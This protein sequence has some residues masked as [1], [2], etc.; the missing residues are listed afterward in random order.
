MC[1]PPADPCAGQVV[2]QTFPITAACLSPTSSL[3]CAPATITVACGTLVKNPNYDC[4]SNATGTLCSASY[5]SSLAAYPAAPSP[6]SQACPSGQS[7]VTGSN[8]Y[9][10]CFNDMTGGIASAV[11]A[12]NTAAASA[13]AS[14]AAAAGTAASAVGGAA[15]VPTAIGTSIAGGGGGGGAV[16]GASSAGMLIKNADVAALCTADPA[17]ALCQPKQQGHV[18]A[19]TASGLPANGTGSWY[20]KRYPSGIS[21]VLTTNFNT[22]KTTPLFSLINNIV[23][24]INATASTGCFTISVWHMGNQQLC[25]P[26][27]ALQMIGICMLLTALFAARAIIFGG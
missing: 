14:A 3:T 17:N 22:M 23:P 9:A 27:I 5:G 24:T 11:A 25:I 26:T 1:D 7:L 19:A 10:K 2:T 8:G 13:A 16:L 15:A 4:M 18:Q 20:T 12:A 21:G 6:P